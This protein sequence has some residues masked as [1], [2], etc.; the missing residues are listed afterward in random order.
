MK[1]TVIATALL[2]VGLAAPAV[3]AGPAAGTTQAQGASEQMQ[4]VSSRHRRWHRVYRPHRVHK[5]CNTH[6][7]HGRRVTVCRTIRR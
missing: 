5:V 3:S 7:R 2:F 1:I 6:W 4:D